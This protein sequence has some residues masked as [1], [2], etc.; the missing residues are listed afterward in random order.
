MNTY[1]SILRGINVSGKNLIKMNSLKE[2]YEDMGFQN[3]RTYI[4]SG[5]V[6]FKCLEI[7]LQK[8]E[9]LISEAIFKQFA[10]NVPVL[11]R[12][13]SELKSILSRN[14]F[15]NDLKED[16]SKLHITFLSTSPEK[17]FIEHIDSESYLPDKFYIMERTVYL[18]CPNGYGKTKLNNN[19]FENKLGVTATTRNLKTLMELVKIAEI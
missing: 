12:E 16:N 15:Q 6:V 9:K 3:I 2:M 13:Y 18:F 11:V 10:L 4:Q 1:I 7:N 17:H 8:L 19:F 5:N 14:P